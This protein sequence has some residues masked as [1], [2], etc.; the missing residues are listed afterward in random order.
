MKEIELLL[1]SFSSDPDLDEHYNA[2][3]TKLLKDMKS[4]EYTHT[5]WGE[6]SKFAL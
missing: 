1:A 2:E 3:F 6:H 5:I 4:L